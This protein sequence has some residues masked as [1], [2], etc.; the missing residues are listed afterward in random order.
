MSGIGGPRLTLQE[1]RA[2][3]RAAIGKGNEVDWV[4]AY[5]VVDEAGNLISVQRAD[6]A[7]A[8]AVPL[9]RAKAHLAAR[10]G[11]ISM[12]FEQEVEAH[13]I[14]FHAY[15]ALQDRPLFGGPGATP[16]F[17]DGQVVGGFS[18]SAS[19]RAGSMQMKIDGKQFSREDV[20]TAHALQTDYDDQHADTP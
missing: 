1:A 15:L 14:R 18:S 16:V 5:A 12:P 3:I 20:V 19:Y 17:K 7:P 4:S 6:G 10:T 11:Q 9:A 13:P 2:I 8:A